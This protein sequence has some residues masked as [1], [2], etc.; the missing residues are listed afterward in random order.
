MIPLAT[1]FCVVT[2]GTS[3]DDGYDATGALVTVASDLRVAITGPSGVDVLIGGQ[4]VKL[5]WV[6]N[7][8]V[9]DIKAGD[10]LTDDNGI[11]Y[12]VEWVVLRS[13]LGLDHMFGHLT[14]VEGAY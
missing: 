3:T 1:N 14:L 5:V 10:T 4:R 7:S 11:A 9:A 2:R 6:F 8:D 13:G 12:N